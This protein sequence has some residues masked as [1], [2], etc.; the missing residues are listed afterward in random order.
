MINTLLV[1]LL[2]AVLNIVKSK[3]AEEKVT[4]LPEMETFDKYEVYSGY[5]PLGK[6]TKRIHYLLVGS[7]RNET[8]DPLVIWMNGGP[9]CSSMLGFA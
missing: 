1:L 4:S 8:T 3:P 6:T 7:A 9:G 5:V 2:G